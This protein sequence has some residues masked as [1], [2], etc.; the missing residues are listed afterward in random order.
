[1]SYLVIGAGAIGLSIARELHRRGAGRVAIIDAGRETSGGA[2]WAAAGMLAPNADNVSDG[3]FYSD[4]CSSNDLYSTFADELMEETGIDIELDRCGSI[5]LA[6]NKSE[7]EEL[8]RR[9]AQLRGRGVRCTVLQPFEIRHREPLISPD[10]VLG[11]YFPDEGCVNNRKLLEALR[12]YAEINEIE[13]ISESVEE[14]FPHDGEVCV[15][16]ASGARLF[17]GHTILA[18]GAWSSLIKFRG[19]DGKIPVKPIRGQM[20][21]WNGAGGLRHIVYS[22]RGYLTPRRDGRILAG[23][24]VEDVGFD[25]ELTQ[26]AAKELAEAAAEML[27]RLGETGFDDHWAGLRPFSPDGLPIIGPVD[28]GLWVATAHYRNGILLAPYT[29]KLIA[30][31]LL[32]DAVKIPSAYSPDRFPGAVMKAR[33]FNK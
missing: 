21:A 15:Q 19:P 2:S 14:V 22:S 5:F 26:S 9:E 32:G 6:F 30:G 4:C 1:M 29:A 25:P 33:V 31:S 23:A 13:I 7:A 28:E 16:T 12:R 20:I 3:V 10:A 17:A 24:T 18:T 8:H 11:L 27:P